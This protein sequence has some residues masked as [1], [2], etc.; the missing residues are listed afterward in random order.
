VRNFAWP[1]I[2][3]FLP[4]VPQSVRVLRRSPG[5]SLTVILTLAAGRRDQCFSVID[6]ALLRPLP[7]AEADA[8][9]AGS[10]NHERVVRTAFRRSDCVTG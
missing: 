5:F 10:T 1:A 4:N 7:F 8:P 3:G 2:A 6:S 9:F